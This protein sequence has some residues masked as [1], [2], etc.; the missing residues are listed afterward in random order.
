MKQCKLPCL[1]G[2]QSTRMLE[3]HSVNKAWSDFLFGC[4]CN[5]KT[6]KEGHLGVFVLFVCLFLAAF[7]FR[8]WNL[9]KFLQ[10]WWPKWVIFISWSIGSI[11]PALAWT[12]KAWTLRSAFGSCL[13]I[14]YLIICDI[15]FFWASLLVKKKKPMGTICRSI[16][17]IRKYSTR[18]M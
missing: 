16:V 12:R 18:A 3:T 5:W 13:N 17:M 10:K 2:P 1:W 4:I 7:Y 11:L 9:F 14:G 15:G 6:W 8:I